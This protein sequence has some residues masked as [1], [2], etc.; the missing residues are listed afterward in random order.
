MDDLW[1]YP[2]RLGIGIFLVVGT[3]LFTGIL[4]AFTFWLERDFKKDKQGK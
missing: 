2:Y 3:F 4:V 1:A